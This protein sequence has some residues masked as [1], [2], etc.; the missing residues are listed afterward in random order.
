[1][2]Y[3]QQND[4]RNLLDLSG[5]WDFQIDPDGVGEAQGWFN[6]LADA[7]PMA[8]PSSW[9]DIYDDIRDY[10][11]VA[12]YVTRTYVPQGWQGE[13]VMLR[14]GSA[15]Y[16][17][18]VWVNGALVGTHE[19][20]HL[21]FV[22]DVTGL[23]RWNAPNTIAVQ[24]EN[25]LLP[26]RVPAGNVEGGLGAF[27]RMFPA[28]TFD[29]FPYAGLHRAVQLFSIPQSHIRDVTVTTGMDGAD[30]IVTVSVDAT[31]AEK[32]S[33]HLDGQALPL[34]FDNGTAQAQV[35]VANAR[36]WGPDDPYLYLL[37]VIL[38]D[39]ASPADRYTLDIGI[40]T[41]A[42]AGGQI[43]LNG[44]P[45]FLK[46]FGRHEDF[47]VSGRGDNRPVTVKDY[48][49]MKWIGANSYRTAHY[50]YSEEQ[51]RM[52]DR[53]GILVIDEIPNV[54]LQFGGGDEAVAE[55]LRVCKQQM[56]EL[57][58]RDKN[59]PSVIMW[60]IANEPMP[61]D[62][63]RRMMG[64]GE[65]LPI[66][67][68]T[69]AFFQELYDLCRAEDPTRLV[70]LVGVGGGP[71]EWLASSDVVCINRYYGWYSQSGQLDAGK[72][73][74]E[75][76][77]DALYTRLG[78]PII[79]TEFGADTLAGNHSHPPA[80]WSEEYQVEMLRGYLDAAAARPFMAGLHIWN[81][82]DFKTAQG[83]MRA[84]SMNH[85]GV[86]TRER[87]PKMAAHFLRERWSQPG[88]ERPALQP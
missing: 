40:R 46:G 31:S 70:T 35:R 54:S 4:R 86:F 3:P 77:L 50:P 41:V 58:A 66:D 80:M 81:F 52:A 62:F 29:F 69:T 24:V 15:N 10:L 51:M 32:G 37:T 71:V 7:R 27:M 23:M 17:A 75:S 48:A 74:L 49:L 18:K 2:L 20:G 76:E 56:S 39:E 84:A 82:A 14:V 57:I 25:H 34:V 33:I 36:L 79:I 12:W 55:R 43:L 85:K 72:T 44:Q 21:P 63:G 53:E 19:G 42:V 60:S 64:G 8:V 28:A 61:S 1:M 65:G 78:K 59:H 22:L 45:I 11:G 87:Q 9:N 13:R 30:G 73:A 38:G 68:A 26:N 5:I 16:A 6:G 88:S 67:P 83:I 47:A